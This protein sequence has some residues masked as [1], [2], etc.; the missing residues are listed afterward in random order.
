[1]GTFMSGGVNAELEEPYECQL[2]KTPLK[3]V[4]APDGLKRVVEVA[5]GERHGCWQNLPRGAK[6]ITTQ[7]D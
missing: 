3:K 7:D 6:V 1:M 4:L 2:C 5:S